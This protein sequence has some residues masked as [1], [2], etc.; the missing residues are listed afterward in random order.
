MLKQVNSFSNVEY[1]WPC[2]VCDEGP[3]D[4]MH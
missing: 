4:Y 3:F 1:N 2:Y